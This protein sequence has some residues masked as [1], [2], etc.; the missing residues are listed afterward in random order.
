MTPAFELAA[1]AWFRHIAQAHGLE[2]LDI[3]D[4]RLFIA[5]PG[6]AGEH[7]DDL[8]WRTP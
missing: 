3:A 2:H 7:P 8:P 6:R 1:L 5:T 4:R